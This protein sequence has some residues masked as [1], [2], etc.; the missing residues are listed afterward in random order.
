MMDDRNLTSVIP[1]HD[2][3]QTSAKM[4][5]LSATITDY[6]FSCLPPLHAPLAHPARHHFR[7]TGKQLRARMAIAAGDCFGVERKISLAWATSVELL[8]NASLVHDDICDGDTVRRG[9]PSVWAKYGKDTALALGDW[10]IATAFAQAAIAAEHSHTPQL[11]SVLAKHMADTT[12]GQAQEFEIKSYPDWNEYMDI[13]TG[14][15]APLFIAPV[16]GISIIARRHDMTAPLTRFFTAA[17]G[18]YQIANDMLNVLGSDGAEN[19]ASDLLR[20]APNAVIVMFRN[21]LDTPTRAQ[22]NEFL[23]QADNGDAGAWQQRIR[24]SSA[25]EMTA[26][27]L[28]NMLEEAEISCAA[29]PQDCQVIIAPIQAQLRSVCHRLTEGL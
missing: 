14:K 12:Q 13:S 7:K 28:M 29:L 23:A 16:E 26:K 9:L 3:T 21:T 17:G 1:S 8:H 19:P 24:P 25:L 6:L 27:A 22:F 18:C 10:M 15:T 4:S 2:L 11:V 5:D 20:R